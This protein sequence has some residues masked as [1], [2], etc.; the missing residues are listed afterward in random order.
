VNL[1]HTLARRARS[2]PDRRAA[3]IRRRE[4]HLYDWPPILRAALS[5]RGQC[6]VCGHD[7]ALRLDGRL[8]EHHGCPGGDQL[9]APTLLSDGAA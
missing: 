1:I 8:R 6:Q 5:D 7:H 2:I 4:Q 9:P 3:A